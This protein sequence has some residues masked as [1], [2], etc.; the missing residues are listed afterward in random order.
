MINPDSLKLPPALSKRLKAWT[1][2]HDRNA[3]SGGLDKK[4]FNA[5]GRGIARKLQLFLGRA[6]KVTYTPID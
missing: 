6:T 4:A 5:E 2:D 3:K 1:E